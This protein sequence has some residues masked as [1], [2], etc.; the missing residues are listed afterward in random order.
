M[1]TTKCEELHTIPFLLFSFPKLNFLCNQ[2]S[3]QQNKRKIF[4]INLL[5]KKVD[6]LDLAPQTQSKA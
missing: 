5:Q 4:Q 1:K 2:T 6:H 3:L